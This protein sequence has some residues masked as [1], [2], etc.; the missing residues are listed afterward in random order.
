MVPVRLR[1][2]SLVLTDVP[3][4]CMLLFA[5]LGFYLWVK[6][7]TILFFLLT[8]IGGSALLV[9][10]G[11]FDTSL[12]AATGE[13]NLAT[14]ATAAGQ[15]AAALEHGRKAVELAHANLC[16]LLAPTQVDSALK[17]CYIAQN[18]LLHDPLR[19]EPV[20]RYYLDSLAF[21]LTALRDDYRKAH[22][23]EP[24]IVPTAD[25]PRR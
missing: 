14:H 13:R 11:D 10:E 15:P 12:D 5:V 19:D 16:V 7:R 22:G 21:T 17:E 3:V 6:H 8:A 9:Y 24:E 20:R 1:Y 25:V 4:T 2:G 23:H 18:L